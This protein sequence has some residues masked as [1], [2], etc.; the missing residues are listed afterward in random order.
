MNAR[1]WL[2]PLTV[3]VALMLVMLPLPEA[4][5]PLRPDWVALVVL[6]WAVALPERFGLVFAW[7][8]GLLL[9][10]TTG[11]LLGQHALGLVLIAAIALRVHQRLRVFPLPHQALVVVAL[12]FFKQVIVL[13]T[14]GVAGRA[15]EEPWL[16]M[17]APLTAFVFWPIVFVILRDLRRRHGVS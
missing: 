4:V 1:W 9:D 8:A 12:V 5:E 16:Y 15:P 11:A 2:V 14:S 3:A 6:Y 7:C 13:W 17:L 10:V